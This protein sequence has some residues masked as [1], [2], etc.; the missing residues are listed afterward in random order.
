MGSFL[1]CAI[2]LFVVERKVSGITEGE[3]LIA[4]KKNMNDPNDVLKNWDSSIVNPCTWFGVKCNGE[5]VTRMEIYGNNIRGKIPKELGNL[6]SL[7]TLDLYSNRLSGPIP[8]TLG[9]LKNLQF[10]RLNDNNLSGNI[11]VSLTG[12]K[13]LQVLDFSSNEL[14]G[15]IPVGG[16]LL[17]FYPSGFSNNRGLRAPK[18]L[19]LTPTSLSGNSNTRAIAGGAAAGG[20]LLFVTLV[21]VLV[22]CRRRRSQ[23][24]F[25]DVAAEDPPDANDHHHGQLKRFSLLELL[26]ATDNFS[27]RNILGVGG[28]GRVYKGRLA[29]GSLVAVK[30]LKEERTHGEDVQFQTE[31]EMISMAV[32]RNLLRLLGFCSTP[33]ERLLVYPLMVN[34]SVASC[35][36]GRPESRPALDWLTRKR[37]AV[38]AA[39]GLAYLHDHCEPKIIHR[40]IKAANIL[41]DE[42]FEA[43]VGDF[44]L[45]KLMDYKATHVTTEVRGTI[46]YIAPEYLSTGQ[47]SEKTDVFGYGV[48]LLELITGQKAFDLARLAIDNDH[49]MLLDW[50]REVVKE[51]KLGTLVDADLRGICDEQEVEE[52]VK[53]CLLC[54]Q[55]NPL[56]RPRMSQVVRMLESEGMHEDW[57]QWQMEMSSQQHSVDF[58]MS[59]HQVNADEC[60]L[61]S[62]SCIVPEELSGPR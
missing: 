10:L 45:A 17:S 39:R 11:P 40:D 51:K 60:T 61:S 42:E 5:S 24:H 28:F 15:E 36:R 34:G 55:N 1:L 38:G 32:H 58:N 47:S 31:M 13:L 7:V 4:L 12:L 33:T 21:I 50:V 37:I 54:T 26:V 9:K 18:G 20:A 35:L 30:R 43:V 29:D 49:I 53:V 52:V 41:L 14:S 56:R 19:P 46:G 16:S 25:F 8:D 22:Y 23:E 59:H 62:S 27:S 2:L 57:E 6:T 3:A 44:G 48:M